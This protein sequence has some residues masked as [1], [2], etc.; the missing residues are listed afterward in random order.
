MYPLYALSYYHWW[1]GMRG[2]GFWLAGVPCALLAY[3]ILMI[4]GIQHCG[5]A[6]LSVLARAEAVAG[7]T[8]A[9]FYAMAQNFLVE[10]FFMGDLT[11][12]IAFYAGSI[13]HAVAVLSGRTAYPRWFLVVSP[14][15]VLILTM[16]IG[17]A[18]PAPLAGFVIAPFGTWFMLVPC[19]ASTVWLWHGVPKRTGP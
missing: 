14:L 12:L 17:Y 18:L 15:G 5:W 8:D 4:G 3:A 11:A 1:V 9:A 7:C 16:V 13:W 10:H 6:F 2:A 19:V